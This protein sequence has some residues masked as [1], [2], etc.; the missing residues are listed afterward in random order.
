MPVVVSAC[1]QC[2]P[3]G[4]ALLLHPQLSLSGGDGPVTSAP[5]TYSVTP[6]I[7]REARGSPVSATLRSKGRSPPKGSVSIT[8]PTVPL[9]DPHSLSG[10]GHAFTFSFAE[11]TS[12]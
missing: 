7:S 2:H 11:D 5:T 9:W 8:G 6:R 4:A 10:A 1:P 12:S 3:A